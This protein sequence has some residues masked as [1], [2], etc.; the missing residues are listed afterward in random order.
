M[1]AITT[2]ATA[3]TTR[4]QTAHPY[5]LP[6]PCC[7]SCPAR[8]PSDPLPQSKSSGDG[9]RGLW[10]VCPRLSALPLSLSLSLF[11]VPFLHCFA[12]LL[13]SANSIKYGSNSCCGAL[14]RD[15]HYSKPLLEMQVNCCLNGAEGWVTVNA[16]ALV[17]TQFF[18]MLLII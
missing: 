15:S 5:P 8:V 6:L 2:T 3:K 13:L 17:K 18:V 16:T 14:L 9:K 10:R 7:H 1:R 11:S 12:V 4:W